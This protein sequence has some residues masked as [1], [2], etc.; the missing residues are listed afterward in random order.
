MAKTPNAK[1]VPAP[2]YQ[3]AMREIVERGDVDQ[4]KLLLEEAKLI[5]RRFGNLE[6]A[7]ADLKSAIAK[8]K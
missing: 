8:V 6:A 3:P 1:G 4:M 5:K 7:I 2:Y